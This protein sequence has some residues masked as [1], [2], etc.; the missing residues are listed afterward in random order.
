MCV[1]ICEVV[2]ETKDLLGR[3]IGVLGGELNQLWCSGESPGVG[4]N[5]PRLCLASA[6]SWRCLH[7]VSGT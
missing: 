2:L 7:A 6:A 5:S 3:K 4:V 1:L